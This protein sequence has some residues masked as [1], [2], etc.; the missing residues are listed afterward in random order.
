MSRRSYVLAGACLLVASGLSQGARAGDISANYSFGFGVHGVDYSTNLPGNV[1]PITS[2]ATM[3]Q[4]TRTGGTDTLVPFNFDSFCAEVGETL[5]GSGT[6]PDVF[7]LLGSTT[8]TGGISGPVFFDP[9][10]TSNLERLWGGYKSAVVDAN[11]M[12]AF[13]L[14]QWEIIF[15]DDLTLVQGI[16]SRLWVEPW[17]FQAG[18]TDYAQFMLGDI[19]SN[20]NGPKA[21]LLLL[22]GEHIQDQVTLVPEPASMVAFGLGALALIRRRRSRKA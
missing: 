10:R 9:V 15:D 22:T 1:G 13:Q 17:Q 7:P 4:G 8:N 11:S 3:F 6:H 12:K 20:P 5:G 14:A 16:G 21:G 19:A 18:V 2:N